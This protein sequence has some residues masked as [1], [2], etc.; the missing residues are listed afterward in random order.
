M[1]IKFKLMLMVVLASLFLLTVTTVSF[2]GMKVEKDSNT[3]LVNDGIKP[4]DAQVDKMNYLNSAI[5]LLL[6]ADRDAHQAL[7]AEKDILVAKTSE[8]R[9]ELVAIHKENMTQ[10][11][12]R[13]TKSINGNEEMNRLYDE[14]KVKFATWK[15]TSDLTISQSKDPTTLDEAKANL[16]KSKIQFEEM[17]TV[18]NNLT[19]L[20]EKL[21]AEQTKKLHKTNEQLLV[22]AT[23]A[24]ALG[25][26][27]TMI[28]ISVSIISILLLIALG[29]WIARGIMKSLKQVVDRIRDIAEG[30]GDLTARVDL[31]TK[32]E[33]GELAGWV[34]T[35][36]AQIHDMVK[37]IS[38]SS[39][40]VAAAA[41]EI[42]ATAEQ[43]SS[44]AEEQ[45]AQLEQI[46]AAV[47]EMSAT[48]TEVANQSNSAVNASEESGKNAISG[49]EVVT[50]AIGK[51]NEIDASVNSSKDLILSLGE[52]SGQIGQ[53]VEV[54]NDIAD[55]TNLLALNAAIEAAR[56]GEAGR[57]F[58]VVADEVR[59]LS[60][61]TAKAT[62][63]VSDS[64]GEIQDFTEKAVEGIKEGSERVVEGVQKAQEA[65]VSLESILESSESVKS[66]VSSI[67]AAAEEQ[68][69][70]TQQ[71]SHSIGLINSAIA[72]SKDGSNQAAE[73]STQLS[74]RAEELRSMVGRFKI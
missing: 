71:V 65:G 32:D 67:S 60:E 4:L 55:Q 43:M 34:D 3:H 19:I 2:I 48:A 16:T 14:F 9:L 35:F 6:N 5:A 53:V 22:D 62:Q 18:I 44:S 47:E 70:A 24:E 50:G 73:A 39:T 25:D 12:D 23:E 64:I 17:R 10:T 38:S 20:K 49:G 8:R 57:G 74:Y 61:R 46:T 30:E 63:E 36:L 15:S 69:A 42:A 52:K 68:A 7:I 45:S 41:T 58:A 1:K 56:A 51:I 72:Q 11:Y 27:M 28:F 66:S 13:V 21:I 40:E 26:K 59:A 54:I 29:Y 31:N 33:L 37:I